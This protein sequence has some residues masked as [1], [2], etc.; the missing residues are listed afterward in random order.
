L[1]ELGWVIKKEGVLN[2]LGKREQGRGMGDSKITSHNSKEF[3][4]REEKKRGTCLVEEAVGGGEPNIVAKTG[5]VSW[6]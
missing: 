2:Q 4:Y 5:K 3:T 6:C 1:G